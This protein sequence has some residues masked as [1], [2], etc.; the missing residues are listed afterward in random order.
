MSIPFATPLRFQNADAARL[1]WGS[2]YY[3]I[4]GA[5]LFEKKITTTE[6]AELCAR[7]MLCAL[8]LTPFD[9]Q[10]RARMFAALNETKPLASEMLGVSFYFNVESGS[11]EK[12]VSIKRQ[13]VD[14]QDGS[15][16]PRESLEGEDVTLSLEEKT[17]LEKS[18]NE[19]VKKA[20]L[21]FARDVFAP[22]F[23]DLTESWK[24]R[25]YTEFKRHDVYPFQAVF[26]G[27]MPLEREHQGKI[28]VLEDHYGTKGDNWNVTCVIFEDDPESGQEVAWGGF[29]YDLV[30]KKLKTMS[31][32][33][34]KYNAQEWMRQF[35][36][37]SP[38]SLDLLFAERAK[39]MR[40]SFARFLQS[41]G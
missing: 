18:L 19:F 32:F 9:T 25:P 6:E 35:D 41:K 5:L 39:F 11:F 28:Y 12:L 7:N 13:Q 38:F 23:P 17:Q 33:P 29:R 34:A 15:A 30:S 21:P 8:R 40:G 1:T 20:I 22:F 36:A 10:L 2:Q 16:R 27:G 14:Y 4:Q 37:S 24:T 26:P 3:A 31:E